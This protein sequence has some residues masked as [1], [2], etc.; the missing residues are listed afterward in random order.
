MQTSFIEKTLVPNANA[1]RRIATGE[2]A[3]SIWMKA[4]GTED[5]RV[6][7]RRVVAKEEL[8]R[9]QIEVGPVAQ[10]QR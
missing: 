3:L 6:S 5:S 1:A 7:K 2:N 9:R 8:A 10:H 4:A